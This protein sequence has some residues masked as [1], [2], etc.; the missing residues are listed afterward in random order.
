MTTHMMP[1]RNVTIGLVISALSFLVA[2]YDTTHAH[3]FTST[4]NNWVIHS[5]YVSPISSGWQHLYYESLQ[6]IT[7]IGSDIIFVLITG[8]IGLDLLQ[9]K[10]FLPLFY[11]ILLGTLCVSLAF[12]LKHYI[13]SPRPIVLFQ[14]DSFPSGHVARAS[15]WC[16]LVLFLNHIN[17]Y[18]VSRYWCG[19][20]IM[21][22]LLVAF[23]RL[24][25]G[26]HWL[27][28]VVAAY[29][30]VIFTFLVVVTIVDVIQRAKMRDSL[31]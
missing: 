14:H 13:D 2:W 11:C 8:L 28:D 5:L 16:G 24:G 1:S 4:I 19:V 18:H 29:A 23:S 22:P 20:L 9:R 10:K 17:V 26:F 12:I 31:P 15:V 6:G 27:S 30:L 21:L 3:L 25:M 7:A